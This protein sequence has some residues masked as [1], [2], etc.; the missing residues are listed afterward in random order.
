MGKASRKLF[1]EALMEAARTTYYLLFT[2]VE[3]ADTYKEKRVKG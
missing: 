1:I 3:L 2:N